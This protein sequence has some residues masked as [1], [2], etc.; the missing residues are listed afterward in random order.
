MGNSMKRVL[1]GVAATLVLGCA[2]AHERERGRHD[3]VL[4]W[5][6]IAFE[7][8]LDAQPPPEQIRFAAILH[9]AVFEGVNAVT[10]DYE[11]TLGTLNAPEGASAS[12]AAVGAAHKVLSTYFPDKAA[13]F[14]AERARSLKRI[15]HE[16]ARRAGLEVGEAAAVAVM[17]SRQNDGSE[18]SEFYVPQSNAPGEWQLTAGCPPNGGVYLHWSKVRTFVIPDPKQ[19]RSAP[20][21]R[22]NSAEYA[23]AFNETSTLGARDSTQR[24]ADRTMVAKFYNT[25]GDAQL[26]NPIT[27][28]LAR[29][30][31]Q[32]LS[33][34]A[35]L[36]ALLNMGLHDLVVALVD[37]KY[38]Y[39]FWRPET[40]IP[41]AGSDGNDATVPNA[42]YQPLVETP[43]HPSY[44]SGHAAT[45]GT[46]REILRRVFGDRGHRIVVR[47]PQF[48]GVVYRYSELE[49][50]TRDIDDARVFGGIHFRFDQAA[51]AEQGRR[52]GAFVWEHGLK[53]SATRQ[54][55]P[56]DRH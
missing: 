1:A 40:A 46:P 35:R 3:A 16:R 29:A 43:C 14:D 39:H 15:P 47:N 22:L 27:R 21:P 5:N 36:F 4:E 18:L 37:T 28:Q 44:G 23:R 51:G 45:S 24:P 20:P 54:D 50:I 41:A 42:S 55:R 19:Y 30:R 6:R 26:W 31:R 34:N 9:L 12:A 11:S 56:H 33:Q 49:Q 10:R 52:V 53:P 17:T 7:Q 8:A 13:V 38:H 48:P 25:Y 2:R 32:T